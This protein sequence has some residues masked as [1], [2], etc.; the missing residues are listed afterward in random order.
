MECWCIGDRSVHGL[1]FFLR[2]KPVLFRFKNLCHFGQ[3]FFERL[4]DVLHLPYKNAGIPEKS[5][6]AM[7]V[8]A[9][10]M[11]GFSVNVFTLY[12]LHSHP[13]CAAR[14]VYSHSPCWDT[15]V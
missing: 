6:L 3:V 8:F 13:P 2:V 14:I 5:P 11:S 9:S 10:S 12:T 15:L 1:R 7:N 4:D